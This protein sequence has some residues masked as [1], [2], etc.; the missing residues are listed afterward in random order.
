[1]AY[2]VSNSGIISTWGGVSMYD[3]MLG[4]YGCVLM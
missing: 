4:L 1:M 2:D 3:P